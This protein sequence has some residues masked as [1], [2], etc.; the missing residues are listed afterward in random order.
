VLSYLVFHSHQKQLFISLQQLI[1][2]DETEVTTA[3]GIT[4]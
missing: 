3:Q 2:A 4:A 1:S